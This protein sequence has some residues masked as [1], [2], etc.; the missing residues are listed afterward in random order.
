MGQDILYHS[1]ILVF[2]RLG[3]RRQDSTANLCNGLQMLTKSFTEICK[4]RESVLRNYCFYT[5]QSMSNDTQILSVKFM[6]E[7]SKHCHYSASNC[8]QKFKKIA[9]ISRRHPECRSCQNPHVCTDL[10][11]YVQIQLK[12]QFLSYEKE[13]KKV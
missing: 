3:G 2:F 9:N 6:V 8:L 5:M 4:Y 13:G 7:Y 10:K 1:H 11:R 12:M